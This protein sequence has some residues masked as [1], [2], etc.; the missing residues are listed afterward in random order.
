VTSVTDAIV[1]AFDA[2]RFLSKD[3]GEIC[4]FLRFTYIQ[5]VKAIKA[6]KEVVAED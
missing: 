4:L 2:V 1:A 5:L 6:L 3:K